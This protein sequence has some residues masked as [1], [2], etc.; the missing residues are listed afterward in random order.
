[1]G[2]HR[3]IMGQKPDEKFSPDFFSEKKSYNLNSVTSSHI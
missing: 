2:N 3:R 1:M